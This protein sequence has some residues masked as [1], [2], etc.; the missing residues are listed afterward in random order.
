VCREERADCRDACAPGG[1]CARECVEE[2]AGC[3]RELDACADECR[4]ARREAIKECREKIADVCDPEAYRACVREAREEHRSCQAECHEGAECG[5]DLREC[6]GT[7]RD[8]VPD[9]G[10]DETDGQIE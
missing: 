9:D 8:D 3:R 4:S 7:C 5:P 1:G 6:L 10:I 2:F